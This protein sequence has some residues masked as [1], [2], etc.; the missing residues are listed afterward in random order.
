MAIINT[1]ERVRVNKVLSL[2]SLLQLERVELLDLALLL[3]RQLL[4]RRGLEEPDV[5]RKVNDAHE[6]AHDA[7]EKGPGLCVREH[8]SSGVVESRL[9]CRVEVHVEG[10]AKVALQLWYVPIDEA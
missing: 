10:L 1:E 6:E 8:Q 2:F 3:V 9:H 4:L 5:P 7:D